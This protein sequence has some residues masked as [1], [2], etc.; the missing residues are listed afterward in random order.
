MRPSGQS[1]NRDTALRAR[2]RRYPV[3]AVTDRRSIDGLVLSRPHSKPKPAVDP[4]PKRAARKATPVPAVSKQQ[5]S[6]VLLRQTVTPPKPTRRKNRSRRQ[7]SRVLVP[8]LAA[9]VFGFGVYVSF[10]GWRANKQ[11]VAQVEQVRQAAQTSSGEAQREIPDEKPPQNIG[12]YAVSPDM[13]RF[14]RINDISVNARVLRMGIRQNGE[15]QAPGNIYDAGWYDGSSKPGEH[16]AMVIDGHVHGP[17]SPGVFIKLT[18]L[19]KGARIEIERGDGKKFIYKVHSTKSYPAD[20]VDM[21]AAM[22]SKVAGK[23]GLSLI[24]CGGDLNSANEYSERHIVFAVM[25]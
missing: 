24:T 6:T 15:L 25:E 16:G 18:N 14:I 17:T 10:D 8:A 20:S 9:A 13:P 2:I 1:T 4:K 7:K 3:K 5:R 12:G 11:V 19:K 23:P 22:V 21:N